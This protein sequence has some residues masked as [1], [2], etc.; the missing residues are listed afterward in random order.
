[1]HPE[2]HPVIAIAQTGTRLR[3]LEA[4]E[5]GARSRAELEEV[6]G[7]PRAT[8]TRN[9]QQLI[10]VRCIE[11][12]DGRYGLTALGSI[13]ADGICKLMAA[14][15]PTADSLER[16]AFL[17]RAKNRV[18]VITALRE[19]AMTRRELVETTGIPRTTVRRILADLRDHEMVLRV[20]HEYRLTQTGQRFAEG[21]MALEGRVETMLRLLEIEHWLPTDAFDFDLQAL[22]NGDVT[23]PTL[24]NPLAPVDRIYRRLLESNEFWL[25]SGSAT[26]DT[27][28]ACWRAMTS[29]RCEVVVSAGLL[30]VI[31]ADTRGAGLPDG[32][33]HSGGVFLTDRPI[34]H[35]VAIADDTVLIRAHD[36]TGGVAAVVESGAPPVRRWAEETKTA[37]A[38]GV[39]PVDPADVFPST[40]PA[41]TVEGDPEVMA[42]IRRVYEDAWGG[43]KDLDLID[44][45]VGESFA[46]HMPYNPD[47]FSSEG[48]K[49]LIAR[50]HR[51]FPDAQCSVEEIIPQGE[52]YFFRW[53]GWGIHE[54]AFGDMEP[55]GETV[56]YLGLTL[57]RFENGECVEEWAFAN[58]TNGVQ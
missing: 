31:A 36:E 22:A 12:D 41:T 38:A 56:E 11:H 37:V 50:Y 51:A 3:L 28:E 8:V 13:V 17:L 23:L 29:G 24:T 21:L 54:R 25:L 19:Q 39:E 43:A 47:V 4:L 18:A 53:R 49:D 33:L 20:G 27:L 42:L 9:L 1:M 40:H 6:T 44:D 35:N 2:G 16:V 32:T 55:T 48:Y 58:R 57:A 7:I 45:Y 15:E 5:A 46:R 34:T 26:P 30:D 10:D 52:R 14:I